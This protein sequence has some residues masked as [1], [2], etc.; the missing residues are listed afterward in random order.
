MDRWDLSLV[1]S[2]SSSVGLPLLQGKPPFSACG[3]TF[4]KRPC[5]PVNIRHWGRAGNRFQKA[6]GRRRHGVGPAGDKPRPK[7]TTETQETETRTPDRKRAEPRKP[8][9]HEPRKPEQPPTETRKTPS[10]ETKT[11]FSEEKEEDDEQGGEE[12]FGLAVALALHGPRLCA[13]A[14]AHRLLCPPHA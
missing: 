2:S 11:R 8:G 7:E 10:P 1:S 9:T 5:P 14:E 12:A 3:A 6:V 4:T 13:L